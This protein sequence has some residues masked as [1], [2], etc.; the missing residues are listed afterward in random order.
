M[1]AIID[2]SNYVPYSDLIVIGLSERQTIF[3]E[4]LTAIKSEIPEPNPYP[5]CSI[6]SSRITMKP[7]AV[8]WMIIN[9]ALPIPISETE[10]YAPDQV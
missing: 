10:P 8:S 7:E 2:P 9:I 3:Y 1:S 6:S 4:I 5:F